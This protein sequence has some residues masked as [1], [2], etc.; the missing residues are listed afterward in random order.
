MSATTELLGELTAALG[1][2]TTE[3]ERLIVPLD[4]SGWSTPTPAQGWLVRDQVS[5]LAYFDDATSMA[6]IE[7]DRFRAERAAAVADVDGFT[8]RIAEQSRSMPP[9]ELLAWFQTARA[10]M[11][12]ALNGLDV[13]T[14]VPWYGPDMSVASALTARVMETW[15]HGQDVADALG[16]TRRPTIALRH[17][18]HIGVRTFANSFLTLGRPVPDTAVAVSLV[19][20]DGERWTWG[21]PTAAERV[22][23]RALDFC[24]VVTQRRHLDDTELAVVG[25]VAKEWMEI[26]QAFAGPPG[27]RRAAGQFRRE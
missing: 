20:P 10:A 2:E 15:A 14:R 13:S 19:A 8:A 7:P 16:A 11:V 18:A 12:S 26:A 25:A 9:A 4:D 22:E 5:H 17:V 1:A 3:L 27:S 23:G 21:D 6:A 24:L